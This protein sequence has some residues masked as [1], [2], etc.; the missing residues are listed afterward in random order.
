M[1]LM[2]TSKWSH[3]RLFILLLLPVSYFLSFPLDSDAAPN[4]LPCMLIQHWWCCWV[5]LSNRPIKT[6]ACCLITIPLGQYSSL[7]A[8]LHFNESLCWGW[9]WSSEANCC[10]LAAS[11]GCCAKD[12]VVCV[13]VCVQGEKKIG[14]STLAEMYDS[15]T[16]MEPD[17]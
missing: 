14:N 2:W 6:S 11:P 8:P 17:A 12:N 7:P 9:G 4:I 10:L 3:I 15:R 1:R 13:C 16:W 5:V